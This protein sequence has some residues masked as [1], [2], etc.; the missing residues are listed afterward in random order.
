MNYK[1]S[2]GGTTTTRLKEED[3]SIDYSNSSDRSLLFTPD[4]VS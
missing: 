3:L 2:S 4:I 1:K